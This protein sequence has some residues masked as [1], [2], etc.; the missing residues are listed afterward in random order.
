MSHRRR[1]QRKAASSFHRLGARPSRCVPSAQELCTRNC[2]AASVLDLG[3]SGGLNT[4]GRERNN[5][6][7][8]CGHNNCAPL[9]GTLDWAAAS[10]SACPRDGPRAR[11]RCWREGTTEKGCCSATAPRCPARS[12]GLR[13]LPLP[14]LET[15]HWYGDAAGTVVSRGG[16]KEAAGRCTA[17]APRCPARSTGRR[18][19][20]LPAL[21]IAHWHGDAAGEDARQKESCCTAVAPRCPAHSTGWGEAYASPGDGSRARGRCRRNARQREAAAQQLRPLTRLAR[22]GGGECLC[23]PCS[24]HRHGGAA[25]GPGRHSTPGQRGPA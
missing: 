2:F 25:G 23:R 7:R 24:R 3:P 17:T 14:A 10:A 5:K 1:A 20:P 18:R 9:P 16:K 19:M 22:Q 4:C 11:G 12:T 15:A 8:L 21:E 13:R 6:R